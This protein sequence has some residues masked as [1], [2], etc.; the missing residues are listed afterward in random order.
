MSVSPT[1]TL[2]TTTIDSSTLTNKVIF[3]YQGWFSCPGDGGGLPDSSNWFHW[4]D[5][6]STPT[7]A[8]LTVDFW[9]DTSELTPDE[10][11]VTDIT[12]PDGRS[13]VAYSSYN[14]QTVLRHFQWMGEYGIDGVELQ[15]FL[16]EDISP[17]E[18]QF[19]DQVLANVSLGAEKYGRVFYVRYDP[20]NGDLEVFK[21]DWP[22]LV[23]VLKVT[24]NPRYLHH[25]GLPLVGI[26]GL[27]FIDDDIEPWQAMDFIE[28]FQSNPNPRYRA[29]VVGGIPSYWRTLSRDSRSD[30]AWAAV[31]RS[32]DVISPWSVGRFT[33]EVDANIYMNEVI[34][35][36]LA[37]TARLGI[38][39][40]PTVYPGYSAANL[41]AL[42]GESSPRN[43][44]PRNG[45]QFYWHQV[46]N[47]LR[48]G[49]D[50]LYVSMFDEVDEGTAMF[51][52][53]E[54]RSDLPTGD[55]LIPLDV[56]GYSLPSD[57]YLLLGRETGKALRHEIPLSP[58]MPLEFP[59][60]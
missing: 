37:E 58:E 1:T 47:A 27:G 56:D 26:F 8:S 59:P 21:N 31:Y 35:P 53:V 34:R 57:W 17:V 38:D 12:L 52:L 6:N 18:R 24:E 22:Y 16:W 46:Y 29:T 54:T 15:R 9:P 40:M 28:F 11:C 32:L 3:G 23:D 44:I 2:T 43:T 51:K 55:F 42:R 48:A 36:D 13:L 39:Y 49:A 7:T 14:T 60:D 4:F 10:Q 30:P 33:N 25:N 20:P 5:F 41:A 45:G 50:M 19:R